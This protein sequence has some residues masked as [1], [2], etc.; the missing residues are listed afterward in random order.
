MG[1]SNVGGYPS[2]THLKLKTRKI[3]LVNNIPLSLHM[4]FD[5]YIY[6]Y[7]Y[8]ANLKTWVGGILFQIYLIYTG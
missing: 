1:L 5:I 4:V 6:I 7:I 3:S 2:E 8:G